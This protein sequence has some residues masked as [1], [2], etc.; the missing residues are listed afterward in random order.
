MKE[1][2]EI[3]ESVNLID[4][5]ED[6]RLADSSRHPRVDEYSTF[7]AKIVA[8]IVIDTSQRHPIEECAPQCNL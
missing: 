1:R 3:R 7:P 5:A 6:G 4:E 8:E 2:R